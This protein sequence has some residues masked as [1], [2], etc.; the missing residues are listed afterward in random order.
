MP[1]KIWSQV[2][3]KEKVNL[4]VTVIHGFVVQAAKLNA[5]QFLIWCDWTETRCDN[6]GWQM[7][8]LGSTRERPSHAA[9]ILTSLNIQLVDRVLLFHVRKLAL[10]SHNPTSH[11]PFWNT[12]GL[13]TSLT[14]R[15]NHISE[16]CIAFRNKKIGEKTFHIFSHTCLT[17]QSISL[18]IRMFWSIKYFWAHSLIVIETMCNTTFKWRNS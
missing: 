4:D 12:C 1:V 8:S 14:V 7:A 17:D 13:C 5:D 2:P 18:S 3:E 10:T 6:I 9:R 11:S 15:T 16:N